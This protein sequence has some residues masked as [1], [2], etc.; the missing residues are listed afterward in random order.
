[1]SSRHRWLGFAAI[2]AIA[3][4]A[5]AACTST[6][7]TPIDDTGP[8][9]PDHPSLTKDASVA[10]VSCYGSD[11]ACTDLS[12]CGA[13]VYATEV[14]QSAPSPSGGTIVPGLY[15]MTKYVIYTGPS[16]ASGTLSNWFKE[17]FVVSS[18]SGDGGVDASK[19]EGGADA[20]DDAS[21]IDAGALGGTFPWSDVDES[22]DSPNSPASSTGYLIAEGTSLVF[23]Y[24]CAN[25][26]T[27]TTGYTATS[28]A[29]LVYIA[30]SGGLGT[31]QITY[32]LMP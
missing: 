26:S 5:F 3:G 10:S 13:E 23:Q 9:N 31:A 4:G 17:T 30:D 11:A 32:S 2:P 12:L 29:I 20:S 1:M 14:A 28:T 8:A 25:A 6:S 27:V 22:N 18:P 19:E 24:E 21:A 15:S 7:L 16:G